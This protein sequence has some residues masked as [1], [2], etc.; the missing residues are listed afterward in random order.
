LEELKM[1][2]SREAMEYLVNQGEEKVKVLDVNGRKFTNTNL[3]EINNPAPAAL[4]VR[5]LKSVVDYLKEC[6]DGK[7][8]DRLL[9]NVSSP[10][11]VDVL[12]E[13]KSDASRDTY[14]S[15][16]ADIPSLRFGQFDDVEDFNIMLQ[17]KY[18][19]TPDKALL[20]KVTGCIQDDAVKNVGDNGV[21]QSVTVKI[22]P[23]SVAP[24]EVP[25]PVVLAPYRTFTEVP[26]PESRF[27][28][29]MRTGPQAALFE[30]DGFNWK[31]AAINN[32]KAYFKTELAGM[33]N[34]TI[35]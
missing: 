3:H 31:I 17:S 22:G 16:R 33:D 32:I 20:L 25:N 34:I 29:R 6:T 4:Q 19:D 24:V 10:T 11:N 21:S 18:A 13:I 35:I 2:N 23:A 9:I 5:S 14:I 15:A 27:I 12:S 8:T 26:Q 30:A 28:F 7:A 1:E